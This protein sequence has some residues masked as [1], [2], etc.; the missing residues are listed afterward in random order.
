MPPG[1]HSVTP[2]AT[3]EGGGNGFGIVP[4]TIPGADSSSTTRSMANWGS[5][6]VPAICD[7]DAGTAAPGMSRAYGTGRSRSNSVAVVPDDVATF[8]TVRRNPGSDSGADDA[9][10]IR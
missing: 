9:G 6:T 2:T 4:G 5:I 10:T 7:A 1:R 8:V 3:S